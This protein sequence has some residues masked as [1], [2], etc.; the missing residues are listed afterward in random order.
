M[1]P[2]ER[3]P[4][5]EALAA[6]AKFYRRSMAHRGEDAV[7]P[8]TSPSLRNEFN[9]QAARIRAQYLERTAEVG[10]EA[11]VGDRNTLRKKILAMSLFPNIYNRNFLKHN[12]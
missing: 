12:M 8:S 11:T 9:A 6:F 2:R 10:K 5:D 1:E 3:N 7:L 4:E